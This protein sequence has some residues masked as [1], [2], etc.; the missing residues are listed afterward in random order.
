AASVQHFALLGFCS[1]A[2]PSYW[3][4]Q[5][6]ARVRHIILY[7]AFSL[8]TGKSRRRYLAVRL[9]NHGFSPAALALYLQRAMGALRALPIQLQSRLSRGRAERAADGGDQL[10]RVQFAERFAA[11]AQMGVQV[12]VL[13]SGADFSNV[14]HA[15][16]I[17]EAFGIQGAG[18]AGLH[19]GFLASIDHI[20]TSISAQRAFIDSIR[21][22]VLGTCGG[23]PDSARPARAGSATAARSVVETH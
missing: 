4:A 22:A 8:Q 7:D 3:A 1:G 18:V 14:N 11:L 15:E 9:R 19:T 10:T 6:D 20:A 17:A 23:A 21:A 13:H 16:Q 5:Q 2:L 12:T